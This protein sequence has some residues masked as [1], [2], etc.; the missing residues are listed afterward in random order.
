[1]AVSKFT[2]SSNA[3]DFNLNIGSTYSATTLTQEYPAGA[4]SFTSVAN[5]TSMDLYFYNAQG[6]VCYTN[7]KGV[8]APTGFNKIVIIGGTVGDVLS[9]SYKTTFTT[10]AE[11]TETT[12]G[13]V[14]LSVTPTSL[15]NVNSST[16]VT[17]LNF[18]TDIAATFTGTDNSVRNAKSVVRGSATSLVITR[19]DS[20]P[21]TYSPYN[22][23]VTNPSV[24]YQPT[25]SSANTISVTAGVVP[26]WVTSAT[27]ANFIKT[28]SYSVTVSATDA[29]GGSSITYSTVSG[30]LPTGLNFNTATGV[31]SGTPTDNSGNPYSYTIRATDSGGNYA[32][33][34]F[35][36]S[37]V[38]ADAP[39]IGIAT[40]N[41]L[42]GTA[43]I[44]FIAPAYTGT[45]TITTYTATSSP[46]GYSGTLSQAGSG[47]ITIT[48]I[49]GSTQY[50]FTVTATNSGGVSISSTAS[51]SIGLPISFTATGSLQTFT[52]PTGKTSVLLK[53]WGAG[54][55][56]YG[57]TGGTGGYTTGT[58]AVTSGRTYNVYVGKT[59][60]GRTGGYP[61]GGNAGSGGTNNLASGGGGYSGFQDSTNSVYLAIAG[62]GGGGAVG[63]PTAGGKGGGASGESISGG[64]GTQGGGS[65][66]AGGTAGTTVDGQSQNGGYLTGGNASNPI[67]G[68]HSSSGGGGAGY[69]GGSGGATGGGALTAAPGG[70]GYFNPSYTSNGSTIVGVGSDPDQGTAGN[71]NTDGKVIVY[72]L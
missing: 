56:S 51:N 6:F 62:A 72:V 2:S 42:T 4:Y 49:T 21:T 39:T 25:G 22:L 10:V 3:N 52:V 19:P 65:Q 18:A 50:T 7:T 17:G 23:T 47:T 9:F 14:I 27:L 58:F 33:R 67:S 16:T 34:T 53:I 8:I 69:F 36:L 37:Q 15:P 41:V 12:A 59:G 64:Y 28:Q 71:A 38:V 46:S 45:S 54:G 20:M 11:T 31:I 26:V 66:T 60:N 24:A 29:D 61:G 63:A 48:G 40:I 35:T 43:S 68:S 32:D 1:M 5:D 30:S 44:P 13:P 70:S 57:G 55:G